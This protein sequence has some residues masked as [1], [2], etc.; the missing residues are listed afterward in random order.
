MTEALVL[1]NYYNGEWV[2][3]KIT[4]FIEVR[5]S[6][7]DELIGLCPKSSQEEADQVVA[8]AKAAFWNWRTTPVPERVEY[9]FALRQKMVEN[10]EVLAEIICAEHGKTV[11]EAKDE[12]TRTLQYVEDACAIPQLMKGSFSEDVAHGVDEHYIRDPLGVFL[13]LPPFNFPAMIPMYFVWAVASGNTAVIKSS[14]ICPMTVQKIMELVD[15][16]GF[17][18]GVVNLI[19]GSGAGLGNY[20]VKHP[21]IAGVSFVGSSEVGLDI[22]K[23][24]SE[25]GKRAQVQ[26]GAKNHAVVM[27]D[28]VMDEALKNVVS[29]C[30]GHVGERCFAVSNVMAVE[31]VYEKFKDNFV[32][33]AKALKVGPGTDSSTQL[34]PVVSRRHLDKLLQ[35]IDNAVKEGAKILLDGRGVKVEGYPDGYFIGPT[36]LEAEPSMQCFQEEIFGPVRCLKKIK[37]L[38]EAIEIVNMSSFGHTAVIYTE[39]GAYAREFTQCCETGQIGINVGTPAPIAF[40]AVGGRKRSFYG[41]TRGRANDAIDFYTDKKVIVTRWIKRKVK[42][43]GTGVSVNW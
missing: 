9:M 21:D 17:P 36:I 8:A 40:Y 42:Q 33:A 28:A 4:D 7:T 5:N 20:L 11:K 13:V 15:E 23:M 26:G 38:D 30:F 2:E 27:E 25:T 43:G 39:S 10:K 3:S 6:A 18:P 31:S 1:K 22:Y 24:A 35:E 19:H 32:A 12:L 34:G 14:S 41:S 16:C 37:D 29:S